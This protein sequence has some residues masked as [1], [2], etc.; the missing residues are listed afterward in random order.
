[1][2]EFYKLMNNAVYGKTCEN[3]KKRSDIR[4]IQSA[5]KLKKLLEKPHCKNF[6]IY[7]EDLAAVDMQKLRVV[8]N[9]PFNV[10]F[11]VLELS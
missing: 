1:M 7:D 11:T 6:E 10:G 5:T 8:I 9:K 4:L 3:Q 2:Q